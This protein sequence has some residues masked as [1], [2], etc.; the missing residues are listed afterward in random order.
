MEPAIQRAI[1]KA[2]AE[3]IAIVELFAN[4]TTSPVIQSI[5]VRITNEIR[6]TIPPEPPPEAPDPRG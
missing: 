1:A 5:L 3:D 2:K 6:K 4:Q